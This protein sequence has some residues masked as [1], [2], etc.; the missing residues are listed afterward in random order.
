V[1]IALAMVLNELVTNVAKYGALS[2]LNGVVELSWDFIS[3]TRLRLT[4]REV[5]GPPVSPPTKRGY[6]TRFIEQAVRGELGG[7]HTVVYAD[8]GMICTIEIEV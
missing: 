3:E 1:A 5:G 7:Q 6:G 8:G 2:S 4:W